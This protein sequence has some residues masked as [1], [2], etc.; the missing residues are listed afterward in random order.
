MKKYVFC[1]LGVFLALQARASD[2]RVAIWEG[3]APYNV[4]TAQGW[5]GPCIDVYKA[6]EA[7]NPKLHFVIDEQPM[8]IRRIEYE[9]S[10]G[11]RDIVCGARKNASRE[12]AGMQ[13]LTQGLHLTGYRLAVRKNDT[14]AVKNWGDIRRLGAQGIVLI[15]Q[16]HAEIERLQSLGI[17]LDSGTPSAEQ[18]LIKLEAGRD[19]FFY[20]RDSYFKSASFNPKDYPDIRLLPVIFDPS[21]AYIAGG[22]QVPKTIITQVNEAFAHLVKSGEL[23]R[24]MKSYGLDS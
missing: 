17:Q 23:N 8:P 13:F 22:K 24:I 3:A 2:L 5:R 20:H 1:F 12:A 11:R 6:I 19:R 16:G 15:M 4:K 7:I 14:V 9:L 21:P 18:N 10:V